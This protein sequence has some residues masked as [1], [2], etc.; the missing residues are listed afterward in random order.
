MNAASSELAPVCLC[1][2]D[3][4]HWEEVQ[5][6][7][8]LALEAHHL[9]RLA[10]PTQLIL[11][12]LLDCAVKA[13][14]LQIF[15]RIMETDL[16]LQLED[17][18]EQLE[19]LYRAELSEHGFQNIAHTCKTAG[20]QISVSFPQATAAAANTLVQVDVPFP[21]DRVECQTEK[22]IA[23]LD[24]RLETGNSDQGSRISLIQQAELQPRRP[25]PFLLDREAQQASLAQIFGELDYG[26]VHF[27]AV[28]EIVS[29]SPSLL[30]R[31]GLGQQQASARSLAQAIPLRFHNDITWGLALA[32]ANGVFKNYRVRLH[33]TGSN[34]ILFNVSGFRHA[35]GTIQS[36]W[37]AVSEDEGGTLLAEGSILSEARIHNITRNYVPQLVEQQARES[38]RLGKTC[39]SNEERP[40]AVLFCD[41]VGFTS[42]VEHNADSESI[43]DTLNSILRR[44]SGAVIR[45]HGSIDK[46]MGD[47]IMAI[48]DKPSDAVLSAIDMQS[49]SEDIN[50]LRTRAGQQ[51][52][53]LRIGIHWGQVVIGNVG[54]A[55]R[56]DWTAIGDVVNIA[57]RIEK[58]CQPGSILIS[59]EVR[60]EV[61]SAR[62]E[63][64]EFGDIFG[65]Q[66]K[67]KQEALVVCY[68]KV[69][70]PKR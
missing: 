14:H 29:V 39:L 54:T 56:L 55:E 13:M 30:T 69:T 47:C 35:D 23:A 3:H 7:L 63:Q 34:S 32:E 44:V 31:L 11:H 6:N 25:A 67:G 45:N 61:E 19:T 65:L 62:A 33:A 52:L 46:F 43:I 17:Q 2:L 8:L 48:F 64:F 15:R 41:I 21:W 18:G 51:T 12:D 59:R 16:G 38:V 50:N 53:Q 28:G 1:T 4:G 20:W 42:Y 40:V 24:F 60:N 10:A 5:A 58:G 68:V 22:L 9:G 49:H 70:P 26:L 57:S 36:L 37:Q 66:V 27:T